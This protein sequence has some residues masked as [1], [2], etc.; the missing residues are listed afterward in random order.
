MTLSLSAAARLRLAW[1]TANLAYARGESPENYLQPTQSG[2][3][4]SALYG[5]TRNNGQRFHEGLDLSAIERDSRG[6]ALDE[7]YAVLHGVV[8][9]VNAGPGRSSYGRYV[10]VEH[11]DA[12]L[13]VYTLYSH[14]AS[15]AP[16]IQ[17]G[18]RVVTGQVL[19]I[20]GRSAGAR[21]LPKSRAHLHF[22]IGVR[23]T[24]D[25]QSW[26]EWRKFGS[27]NHHAIW[28]GINL[29]GIDPLEFYDLFRAK[30]VDGFLDYWKQLSPAVTVRWASP[31]IP[32][33]VQRYPALRVEPM[34]LF[35]LAGWEFDFDRYGV[36]LSF[37][38]LQ[39]EDIADFRRGEIRIVRA[40]TGVLANIAC[41]DLVHR[42]SCRLV[43]AEDLMTN[44]QLLLG[45]KQ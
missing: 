1:P 3:L 22:E 40:D 38:P 28:N 34:P 36:P 41:K 20:M 6:E 43:P 27:R 37:R 32:D 16:G 4:E 42:R 26:Y 35:G 44:L 12:S 25:F 17:P 14:L 29:A 24:D 39:Q 23:L 21:P 7:I 8:R 5:C 31:Q 13:P 15:I 19:G 10:V 2:R 45:I 33:F 11:V 9:Y 18:T 30:R